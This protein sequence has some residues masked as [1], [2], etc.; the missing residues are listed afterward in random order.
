MHAHGLKFTI[1]VLKLIE[2]LN[3]LH[4][5]FEVPGCWGFFSEAM[6]SNPGKL[7]F[8]VDKLGS[9]QFTL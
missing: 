7:H 8:E 5:R 1:Y 4:I 2:W 3:D 6:G 9:M